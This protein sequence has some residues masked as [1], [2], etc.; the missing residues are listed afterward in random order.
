M[1]D[2]EAIRIEQLVEAKWWH[3]MMVWMLATGATEAGARYMNVVQQNYR[4]MI[5]A[6]INVTY[7][8]HLRVPEMSTRI[9][10][11]FGTEV[12]QIRIF[13]APNDRRDGQEN[14]E[15]SN[16]GTDDDNE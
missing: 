4:E 15:M 2:E 7:V 9:G 3:K 1:R 12:G 14:T 6:S 13:E 5:S 11:M 8:W 16:S 10:G